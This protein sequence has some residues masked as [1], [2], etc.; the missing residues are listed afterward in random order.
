V[1]LHDHTALELAALIRKRD[2][3]PVELVEHYLDRVERLGDRL[4]AFITTTPVLA[5]ER[6]RGAADR[7]AGGGDASLPTLFGVPTAIK[8]LTPTAGVRTTM[9]S[10]VFAALVPETGNHVAGQIEAAGL[11]SLGKTNT[12]VFGAACYT[13]ND[14]APD[15][16][17]PWDETRSASGSSGGAAAAVAAGLVP[18]AHGSDGTGSIRTPASVCGLVGFKPSRGV[19]SMAP[20]FIT[21]GTDGPLARTVADAAALLDVMAAPNP[22][23]LYDVA[24][25]ADGYL[26]AAS[27]PAPARL[28]VGRCVDPG[29]DTVVHADC[30]RAVDG[31][32]TVLSE[33]GHEVI[34]I[35]NPW[36]EGSGPLTEAL[37]DVIAVS[38]AAGLRDLVPADA[39]PLLQPL[40]RWLIERG[41]RLS[42]VDHGR[43]MQLVAAATSRALAALA[44]IDVVLTPTVAGPPPMLGQL[45]DPDPARE[46]VLMGEWSPFTPPANLTGQPAVNLPLHWNDAGLPIGVQL[47]GRRGRDGE[48]LA[49]AASIEEVH[50]WAART[51]EA[52]NQ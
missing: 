4:G 18:V 19:V 44:G 20:A 17:T 23:D 43:A 7:L 14:L 28:V 48:L 37:V 2:L 40:T 8:D 52:W 16:R 21:M 22:A 38:V 39:V 45:R 5:Q 51:P 11:V 30:L 42:A 24:R 10:S 25:P 32:A 47:I 50:P 3:S 9:G 13:A 36:R 6:A 46:Y 26:V 35:D 33:L 31:A 1:A 29:T 15:A 34:D 41:E 27:S 49:L 12:P